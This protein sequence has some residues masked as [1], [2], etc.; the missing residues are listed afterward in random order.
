MNSLQPVLLTTTII[1]LFFDLNKNVKETKK[2][3]EEIRQQTVSERE[4]ENDNNENENNANGNNKNN[5][6][7]KNFQIVN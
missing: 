1:I 4:N 3:S 6:N 2:I 7:N 5:A